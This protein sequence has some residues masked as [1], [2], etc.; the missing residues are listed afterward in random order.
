MTEITE[1]IAAGEMVNHIEHIQMLIDTLE[2]NEHFYDEG[3]VAESVL[4]SL[5]YAC[6]TLCTAQVAQ[7]R[8]EELEGTIRRMIPYRN[9]TS[10]EYSIYCDSF[11]PLLLE[12]I[13]LLKE[14]E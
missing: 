14:G 11:R 4:P 1:R 6:R 2:R 12:A 3:M 13:A 7:Q 8:I 10:E 5:K 9:L